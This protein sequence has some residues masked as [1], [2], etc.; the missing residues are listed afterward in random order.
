MAPR[1]TANCARK[2]PSVWVWEGRQ[3]PVL[4]GDDNQFFHQGSRRQTQVSSTWL[5]KSPSLSSLKSLLEGSTPGVINWKI[6]VI[7]YFNSMLDVKFVHPILMI[8][9][10]VVQYRPPPA[11]YSE[12]NSQ[13]LALKSMTNLK[14]IQRL[15][16]ENDLYW[17]T[18]INNPSH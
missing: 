1:L 14:W 9:N 5:G 10:V 6:I 18:G 16:V 12:I 15:P 2:D 7:L 11:Q 8:C 13:M 4:W 17:I 3:A